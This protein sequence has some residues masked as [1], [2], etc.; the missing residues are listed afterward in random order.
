[1][2]RTFLVLAAAMAPMLAVAQGSTM[3]HCTNGSA[4]R[5]VEI[6]YPRGG[7]V[8]C[9]VRYYKDGVPEVLWSADHQVGYCEAQA[10][11]FLMRLASIGW[12]CGDAGAG[13]PPTAPAPRDDT[14]VLGADRN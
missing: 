7:G 6:A 10:R 8:P 1:M 13:V 9:E 14:G 2:V 3:Y 4:V 11:E 12:K 5:E